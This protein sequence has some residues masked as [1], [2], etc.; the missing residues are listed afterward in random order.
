MC[1]WVCPEIFERFKTDSVSL[2]IDI[3]PSSSNKAVNFNRFFFPQYFKLKSMR[4][5]KQNHALSCVCR[6]GGS[7]LFRSKHLFFMGFPSQPLKWLVLLYCV[8][9]EQEKEWYQWFIWFMLFIR[10]GWHF[11]NQTD[12]DEKKNVHFFVVV[13]VLNF[14]AFI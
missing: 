11:C 14:G 1:V 9:A 6:C 8:S 13:V 7:L 12:E 4:M 3:M 10:N 2:T 5:K